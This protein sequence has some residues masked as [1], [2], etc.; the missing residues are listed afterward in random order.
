[1]W[2]NNIVLV[3]SKAQLI[4]LIVFYEIIW[5]C[6]LLKLN[7]LTFKLKTMSALILSA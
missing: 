7:V 3:T 6:V 1:M 2:A 5:L 4:K